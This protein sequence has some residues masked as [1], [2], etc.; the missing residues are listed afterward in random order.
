MKG[1]GYHKYSGKWKAQIWRN[2]KNEYIGSYDSEDEA[3][4]AVM[5]ARGTPA[6]KRPFTP[7][8]PFAA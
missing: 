5:R 8:N 4:R 6:R 2:G 1:V 3:E 7:A